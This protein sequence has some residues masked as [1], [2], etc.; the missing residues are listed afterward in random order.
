MGDDAKLNE[1]LEHKCREFINNEK[2]LLE[3]HK[4]RPASFRERFSMMLL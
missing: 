1:L 4:L 2:E 3:E